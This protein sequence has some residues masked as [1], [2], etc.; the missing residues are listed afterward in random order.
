MTIDTFDPEDA[1]LDI[2]R[3]LSNVSIH[4]LP[5]NGSVEKEAVRI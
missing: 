1:L 5:T 4:K 2:S 3:K